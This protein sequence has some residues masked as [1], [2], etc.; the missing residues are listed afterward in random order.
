MQFGRE[1][2]AIDDQDLEHQPGTATET[3]VWHIRSKIRHLCSFGY[4][5]IED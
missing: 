2:A 5:L 3:C 1:E 4:R